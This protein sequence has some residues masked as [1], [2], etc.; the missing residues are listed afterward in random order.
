MLFPEFSISPSGSLFRNVVSKKSSITKSTLEVIETAEK[1]TSPNESGNSRSTKQNSQNSDDL[2]IGQSFLRTNS[3]LPS[4][5]EGF[6]NGSILNFARNFTNNESTSVFSMEKC[7]ATSFLK[8]SN[9]T[10][11]SRFT[12]NI[13]AVC[14]GVSD[15]FGV[16]VIDISKTGVYNFGAK[17][18]APSFL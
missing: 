6:T 12:D 15:S 4:N 13:F 9:S 5:F 8:T 3:P 17:I 7:S 1:D 18:L 10:I 2:V 14:S 11:R 16:Y